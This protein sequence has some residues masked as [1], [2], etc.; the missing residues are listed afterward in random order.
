M[1]EYISDRV[2]VMYVGRMV[3]LA[4]KAAL[5]SNPLHPYTEALLSAEPSVDI[6]QRRDRITLRG[7]IAN[8]AAPPS[9]CH[10]HPRCQYAQDICK[11][12]IPAWQE[13]KPGHYAACHFADELHLQGAQVAPATV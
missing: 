11:Q 9:G 1:V 12:K 7:E 2:A 3:E 6:E 13:V 10:F 8:P 5:Y 4:P